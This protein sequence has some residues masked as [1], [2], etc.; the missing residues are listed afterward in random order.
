MKSKPARNLFK[1]LTSLISRNELGKKR[2]GISKR[3]SDFPTSTQGAVWSVVCALLTTGG[4][5]SLKGERHLFRVMA[6]FYFYPR[7]MFSMQNEVTQFDFLVKLQVE[8]TNCS[9]ENMQ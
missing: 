4:S 1:Y 9:K 7:C 6:T 8:K 2:E 3:G 5:V